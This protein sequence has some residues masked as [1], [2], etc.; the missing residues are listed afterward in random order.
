MRLKDVIMLYDFGKPLYVE[1]FGE[2]MF[3]CQYSGYVVDNKLIDSYDDIVCDDIAMFDNYHVFD[4]S[5]DYRGL[6]LQ[7]R[8]D[9]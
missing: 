5:I 4:I 8:K 6:R 7:L 3:R 2:K 9:I 1:A